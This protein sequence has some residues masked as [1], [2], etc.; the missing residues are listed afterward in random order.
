ML[1]YNDKEYSSYHAKRPMIVFDVD[2]VKLSAVTE[3]NPKVVDRMYRKYNT[4]RIAKETIA[5]TLGLVSKM[6][7]KTVS[8]CS[9]YVTRKSDDYLKS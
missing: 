3:T 4:E 8:E 2:S 7:T 5:N 6:G 1:D 9:A